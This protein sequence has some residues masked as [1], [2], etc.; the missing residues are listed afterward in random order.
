MPRFKYTALAANGA[1]VTGTTQAASATLVTIA[2]ADRDLRPVKVLEKKSIWQFEITRKKVPARDLMHFSRQLA[3]FT[4]AAVPIIEGLQTIT[5]ET[6]NKLFKKGLLDIIEALEGGSTF[7]EAAARHPEIFPDVYLGMLQSAEMTGRLD[8]VL[9]QLAL[10]LERDLEARRMVTS[11]LVYPALVLLMSFVT[12]GVLAVYVMPKFKT[13]FHTLNAKLPLATRMLLD[14]TSWLGSAWP[15][16]LVALLII[17]S[18][19]ILIDRTE[20]GR[21][22]RDAFLIRAP[23]VG[24]LARHAIIERFCRVLSAMVQAG[25]PLPDALAVTAQAANNVPYRNGILAAR[26]EMLR[27]AGFSEPLGRTKLFPSAIT[28]MFR[29]GEDTGSLDEQMNTAATYYARELDFRIKRFTSLFEPAVIV[30]VGIVVGFVA[31]ALVSAMYG[32]FRQ[33]HP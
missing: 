19:L 8:T 15:Y 13:F 1:T 16:I 6:T 24:D 26:E 12:I 5:E 32:I 7:T 17:A 14:F 33:V 11:A 3:V 9:E 2:L 28:Q 30:F 27:G 21:A 18:A 20:W 22:R 31:I 4:K 29:V 23:V 25:V 10:Y